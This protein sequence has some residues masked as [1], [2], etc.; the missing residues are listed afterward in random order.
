VQSFP[1]EQDDQIMLITDKATLIRTPVK[2]IRIAGRNTQGVT[3]FK[4]DKS[5]KVI[6]ASHINGAM[7]GGEVEEEQN[8]I[9]DNNKS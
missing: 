5:E 2:D 3:I 9:L 4:T 1:V 8:E 6:S 7:L